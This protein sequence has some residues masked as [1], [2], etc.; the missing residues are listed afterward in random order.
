MRLGCLI[1]SQPL[2][3][4][5]RVVNHWRESRRQLYVLWSYRKSMSAHFHAL[6]NEDLPSPRDLRE[7]KQRLA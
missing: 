6:R 7:H 5:L 2:G 4:T 3:F 1:Q